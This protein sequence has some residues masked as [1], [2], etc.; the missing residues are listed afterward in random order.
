LRLTTS[1]YFTPAGTSIHGVGIEPDISIDYIPPSEE[2]EEDGEEKIE[3]IFNDIELEDSEDKEKLKLSQQE[4][5]M[6]QIL[7]EDNQVQSA[8][9]VLKGIHVFKKFS[10]APEPAVAEP[11]ET[12]VE[13]EE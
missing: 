9:S 2:P 6:R 13:P 1:K 10:E 3:Q 12:A 5:E 7:L 11:V 8:I 4:L